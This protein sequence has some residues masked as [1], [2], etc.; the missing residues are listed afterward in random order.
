MLDTI[1]RL[2]PVTLLVFI[3][4]AVSGVLI[5]NDPVLL[6]ISL[7][8]ALS[9]IGLCGGIKALGRYLLMCL[10]VSLGVTII[11]PLVSHRGITVLLY[12]PDGNPMTLESVIYGVFAA[13]LIS[14]TVC[15]FFLV[16][17]TLTSDRIIYLFGRLSP[18]LALLISMTIGF[19]QKLKHRVRDVRASRRA[20]GRD[21]TDGSIIRRMK[22]AAA[23]FGSVTGW[24]LEN[25]VDTA[26]SMNSRGYGRR[27]RTVWS[28]FI[29]RA[30]DGIMTAIV[31]LCFS[32][33]MYGHFSGQLGYSYYPT[34]AFSGFSMMSAAV[35]CC[36]GIMCF[37]PMIFAIREERRW[38]SIRSES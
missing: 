31:L 18:K 8:A 27:R 30:S 2:H 28:P 7:A 24:A 37:V 4:C 11:N 17:R 29:F 35:C 25:S 32:V 9:Y 36:Y 16:S 10:F 22:N 12:L 15:W 5:I 19:S 1:K 13:V 20:A 14:A 3:V 26:D 38:K 23:V 33:V 34:F 21:I 6:I